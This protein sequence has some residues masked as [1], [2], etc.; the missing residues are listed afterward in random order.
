MIDPTAPATPRLDGDTPWVK[1]TRSGSNGCVELRRHNGTIE[2]RD[3]KDA[4]TGPVLRF[5]RDELAAFLDGARRGE[6]DHLP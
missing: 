3:T 5:T 4:G 2:L 1:A 6:F